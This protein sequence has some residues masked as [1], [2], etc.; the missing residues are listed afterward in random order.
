MAIEVSVVITAYNVAKWIKDAANS[1]LNQTYKNLEV[2]IVNDCSTDETPEILKE[3]EAQDSRVKIINHE[4]NM[5]AGQARKTGITN[6]KGE[7]ILLLDGDDWLDENFIEE[8]VKE[9]TE[10]GADI[11][12]GGI[13]VN[14]E[15]G[16]IDTTSYGKTICTGID[17]VYKFWKERIVFMN[18]KL[19]RRSIHEKVPYCTRRYI[20][21]TPVIIPQLYYANKVAYIPN[22]GYHYRMNNESLTHT[23]TPFKTALFQLLCVQDL[24]QFFNEH[25]KEYLKTIPL[26]LTYPKLLRTIKGINPTQE[27]IQQYQ[28]EWNE[29]TLYLLKMIQ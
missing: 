2:I 9:A 24:I 14:H 10:T 18:N 12:S 29:A 26:G 7:Y 28:K 21:D 1:V 5:G 25:D 15:D 13:T 20:E 16:V 11:V 4:V 17:K 19:I 23:T 6:S 3:I 8:L 27:M 22:C